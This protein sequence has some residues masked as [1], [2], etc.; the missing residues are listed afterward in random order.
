MM[1]MMVM[2]VVMMDS[3]SDKE[4]CQKKKMRFFV[5]VSIPPPVGVIRFLLFGQ[6]VIHCYDQINT[7]SLRI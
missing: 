7:S 4:G 6:S 1:I 3:V 5:L 2:L